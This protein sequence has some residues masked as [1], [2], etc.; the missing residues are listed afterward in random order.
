MEQDRFWRMALADPNCVTD[1]AEL[2][3]QRFARCACGAIE[4]ILFREK[5]EGFR[6]CAC[7]AIAV[8]RVLIDRQPNATQ[9]EPKDYIEMST[10]VKRGPLFV[11]RDALDSDDPDH[12]RNYVKTQNGEPESHGAMKPRIG[13]PVP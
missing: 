8:Q 3:R 12:P 6:C 2:R 11:R 7:R 5:V 4:G 10:W 9:N 13:W 1:G